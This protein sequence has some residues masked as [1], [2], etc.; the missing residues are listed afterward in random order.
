MKKKSVSIIIFILLIHRQSASM[1]FVRNALSTLKDGLENLQITLQ[2]IQTIPQPTV[3]AQEMGH[4][5]KFRTAVPLVIGRNN[6]TSRD[7]IKSLIDVPIEIYANR[8][9]ALGNCIVI[10]VYTAQRMTVF[11]DDLESLFGILI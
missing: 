11:L 3:T 5:C 9:E 2:N 6:F 4:T 10:E 8:E 7:F 1:E